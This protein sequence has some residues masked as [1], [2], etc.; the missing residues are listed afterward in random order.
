MVINMNIL[1]DIVNGALT[2]YTFT[3]FFG[4]ITSERFKKS[5]PSQIQK[6][7]LNLLFIVGFTLILI[8]FKNNTLKPI[9]I[10]FLTWLISL[11]FEFKWYSGILFSV[12][13]IALLSLSE[14]ATT[15]LVSIIFAVDTQT[16]LQGSLY[17]FGIVISKLL[18]IITVL[19]IKYL[20]PKNHKLIAPKKLLTMFFIPF[21]TVIVLMFFYSFFISLPVQNEST[22]TAAA[23]CCCV[24]MVSNLLVF[25]LTN[26]LYEDAEKDIRLKTADSMIKVQA[27]QYKEIMK[28]NDYVLK[29]RH[30]QKHFLSGLKSEMM[31]NNHKN[32]LNAVNE[33]LDILNFPIFTESKNGFIGAIINSKAEEAKKDNIEIDFSYRNLKLINIPSIDLS[34]I[35][36]N[37]LDNAIEASQKIESIDQR[38]IRISVTVHNNHVFINTENNVEEDVDTN[39]LITTKPNG[40]HGFGIISIKNIAE[41]YD[42]EAIFNCVDKTFKANIVLRNPE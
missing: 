36:G 18:G 11:T 16:A 42:G 9:L 32:A 12:S 6:Y 3:L 7:L 39:N 5:F 24:L 31:S 21:S 41:K 20:L 38:K 25:T 14:I 19:A 37:L 13:A 34:I 15:A 23:I 1:I 33:Q 35:L 2:I 4:S 28:H 22:T 40:I 30:D 27:E 17:I 26:H 29:F 8:L 10:T